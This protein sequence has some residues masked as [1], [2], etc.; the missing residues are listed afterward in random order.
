MLSVRSATAKPL[1]NCTLVGDQVLRHL[2]IKR[3]LTVDRM[4]F[5]AQVWRPAL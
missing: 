3:P 5:F 2:T 1:L 4:V